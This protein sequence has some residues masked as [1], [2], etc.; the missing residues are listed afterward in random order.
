LVLLYSLSIISQVAAQQIVAL[1]WLILV[2]I[3]VCFGYNVGQNCG[4]LRNPPS[5]ELK[6]YV[7]GE[8][9]AK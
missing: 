1:E 5:S 9:N 6:R 8:L 2:F 7:P 4:I 3:E